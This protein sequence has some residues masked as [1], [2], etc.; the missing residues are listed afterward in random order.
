MTATLRF[1]AKGVHAALGAQVRVG[2][3]LEIVI[4]TA[5]C[6]RCI[7]V[8]WGA[9]AT[10]V[11]L[12]RWTLALRAVAITCRTVIAPR[13]AI[14]KLVDALSITG[15]T[16][17][18]TV[19]AHVAVGTRCTTAFTTSASA[20]ATTASGFGVANALHHFTACSFGCSCHH[21]AA[22]GLA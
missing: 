8:T 11:E 18:H 15:W 22:W 13:W 16:V 2:T 14:T 12:T 9:W 4:V 7:K 6:A 17:A 19:T 3:G 21:V 20:I 1:M 5:W 10:V